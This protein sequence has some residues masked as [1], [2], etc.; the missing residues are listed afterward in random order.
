[1]SC[2]VIWIGEWDVGTRDAVVGQ[3]CASK[4]TKNKERA[5]GANS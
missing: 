5:G 3:R 4:K 1:M 2:S